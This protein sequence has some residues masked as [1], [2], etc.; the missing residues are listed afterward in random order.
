[1]PHSMPAR[2][3]AALILLVLALV[4]GCDTSPKPTVTPKPEVAQPAAEKPKERPS[5]QSSPTQTASNPTE[6]KP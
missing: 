4:A 5:S 3:Y 6:T 1:M 2:N